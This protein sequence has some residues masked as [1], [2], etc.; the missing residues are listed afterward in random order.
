MRFA[1]ASG[2]MYSVRSCTAPVVRHAMRDLGRHPHRALRRHHPGGVARV[3]RHHA[4]RRV[5]RAGSAGG[6]ASRS[7]ARAAGRAPGADRSRH[8]LVGIASGGLGMSH[9]RQKLSDGRVTDASR[10]ASDADHE[11]RLSGSVHQSRPPA[12]PPGDA[13]L[14]HRGAR[15]AASGICRTPSCC[16]SRWAASSP[17]APSPSRRAGWPT[18]GAATR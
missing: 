3:D 5:D 4:A 10:R 16:R 9:S 14:P 12:R 6:C 17:S 11:A 18:T 13:G 2:A 1:A 15:L 7:R 8:F